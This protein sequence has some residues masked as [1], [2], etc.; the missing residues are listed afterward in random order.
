MKIR[1]KPDSIDAEHIR[2]TLETRGWQLIEAR[3]KE[4]L[5][6][7]RGQLELAELPPAQYRAQGAVRALRL[8]LNVPEIL[9]REIAQQEERRERRGQPDRG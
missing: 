2:Q 7:T 4:T 5:E 8:V 3:I 9:L 1:T 6:A